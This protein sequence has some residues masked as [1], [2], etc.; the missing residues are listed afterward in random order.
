[1]SDQ[2]LT[3]LDNPE[4]KAVLAELHNAFVNNPNAV[5]FLQIDFEVRD[6]EDHL[7][8]YQLLLKTKSGKTP[9]EVLNQA[10]EGWIRAVDEELVSAHID[11]ANIS[12]T[13]EVAKTKLSSLINWHV[14]VAT[15]PELRDAS[16][17][18][19]IRNEEV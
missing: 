5:N 12:D 1:M 17:F 4:F 10:R 15:D 19:L 3:L 7:H 8:E 9:A 16:E 6:V 11:V 2:T 13:Y 14:D 18:N